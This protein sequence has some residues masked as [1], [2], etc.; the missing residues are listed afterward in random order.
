MFIHFLNSYSEVVREHKFRNCLEIAKCLHIEKLTIMQE[1]SLGKTDLMWYTRDLR[2][3]EEGNW[4]YIIVF[5]KGI[6][7][8]ICNTKYQGRGP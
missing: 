3:S 4:P 8:R 5:G 7:S 6:V 2:G 1:T